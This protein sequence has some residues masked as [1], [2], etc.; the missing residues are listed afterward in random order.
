MAKGEFDNDIKV[1]EK[2][3]LETRDF[4]NRTRLNCNFIKIEGYF[5]DYDLICKHC[6]TKIECKHDH[7][8]KYT[9]NFFFEKK[10]LELSTCD[11]LYHQTQDTRTYV[12]KFNELKDILRQFY[13]D[14]I[15]YTK[16]QNADN[17]EGM[18]VPID[19]LRGIWHIEN[20]EQSGNNEITYF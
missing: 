19:M 3:E 18:I 2:F 10:L 11:Y 8:G 13:K 9:G 14:G 4:L 17:S 20:Y 1:G 12:F 5:L 7:K 6:N 15:K 16:A